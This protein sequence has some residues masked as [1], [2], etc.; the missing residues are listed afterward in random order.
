M[1]SI[2]KEL[3]SC[4]SISPKDDGALSNI[5]NLLEQNGFKCF[6]KE[7]GEGEFATKNLYAEKGEG[8][9]NLCFAGHV[10]VVPAGDIKL[11][12]NDP[13]DMIAEEGNI[14]GRGVVDMKGA[15]SAMISAMLDYT[16][17]YS[18]KVSILLTSDEEASGKFGTKKMLE[19]LQEN[20][21]KID[22]AI[23]GEPTSS[24]I[25]GDTIKI[26][27][28]GS[29]NFHLVIHGKQGHV[30]YPEL[31]INPNTILIKILN[32]LINWKIDEG[33][34]FFQPSNLEIISIDTDNDVMNLI[35]QSSSVKF[36]VRFNTKQTP[37]RLIK[38][39]ETI[40]KKYT[41]DFSL[42][43]SISAQAFL[44]AISEFAYEFQGLVQEICQV[45]PQ[46]STSGGT[47]DARFIKDICP[48]L[49]FG[50][51][52]KTAHQINENC[53]IMDLQ[54]L[55]SVYYGAIISYHK[56]DR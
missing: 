56:N 19:W 44:T 42:Q 2:L 23:V 53:K 34:D 35:P 47:S 39:I 15:V 24:E 21:I 20:G 26:G 55:Y 25:F 37:E 18:N 30:A 29:I 46:F 32:D 13:F 27:R 10:D 49:E 52:N 28:R 12:K 1:L 22:F 45:K 17:K 8:A 31:A 14:Y 33:N 54:K 5:S 7:F 40:I 51:L 48:L 6:L 36:N 9:K 43:H 4:V 38:N 3:I 16:N 11:W 50:L 41:A